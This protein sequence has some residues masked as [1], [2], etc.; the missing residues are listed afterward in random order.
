MKL[1]KKLQ[2]HTVFPRAFR[3]LVCVGW[4]LL[5]QKQ[6]AFAFVLMPDQV[7]QSISVPVPSSSMLLTVP[8]NINENKD[9]KP[10]KREWVDR[11]LKYYM[12]LRRIR[13]DGAK[14]IHPNQFGRDGEVREAILMHAALQKIKEQKYYHAEVLC[15]YK[16]NTDDIYLP[17]SMIMR[18]CFTQLL[19]C[20]NMLP[21]R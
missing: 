20:V 12:T 15:M 21:C 13:Y 8:K 7:K 1:H 5:A 3:L 17:S 11:S 9:Y 18:F 2:R 14:H 16:K 10:T 6:A 19:F 4:P